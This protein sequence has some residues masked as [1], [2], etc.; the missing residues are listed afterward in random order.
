MSQGGTLLQ[1]S[2]GVGAGRRGAIESVRELPVAGEEGHGGR[3]GNLLASHRCGSQQPL[4]HRQL[5]P[6]PVEHRR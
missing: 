4:P 6:F 3:G 5:R 1:E 2:G